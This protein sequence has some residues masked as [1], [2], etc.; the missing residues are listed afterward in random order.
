VWTPDDDGY[1]GIP[2][3]KSS[4]RAAPSATAT[5][6]PIRGPRPAG[7]TLEPTTGLAPGGARAEL[8]WQPMPPEL[9]TRSH[10]PMPNTATSP[11]RG[12]W[13]R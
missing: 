3:T 4:H 5:S 9:A 7:R 8:R 12:S 13:S 1:V 10:R 11:S 2:L 6:K